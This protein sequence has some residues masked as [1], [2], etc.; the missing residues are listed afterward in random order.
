MRLHARQAIISSFFIFSSSFVLSADWPQWRGPAQT[1]HV[2]AGVAVPAALP[3]EAKVLWRVKIGDGYASPV[4]CGGKV[5]YLDNQQGDETVHA[6]EAATGKELWHARL[7]ACFKDN[8]VSG[9]RCT[10]TADGNRVYAQSCRG[11]FQCLN[12]DDGKVVWRKNFCTDFGSIFIGEKGAATG[13]SRHGYAGAPVVDGENIIV[14]VG[15]TKGACLVCMK[16]ATGDV[17]WQSQND[18]TAYGPPVLATLCGTKQAVAFTVEGVIGVDTTDGKLLWRSAPMKTAFGRHIATAVIV[19]DLVLVASHQIGLIA[20]R[21]VKDGGGLKAETAWTE[22][23]LAINFSSPVAVGKYLYGLGPAKNIICV[24][25][26]TGS[27][28][29]EKTGCIVSPPD[30]A[31][32]AFL[33][34]GQNILL[35]TD[36]GLLI[37]FAADPQEYKEL[38][39]VQVCGQAWCN[40]AYVDGKLFLRDARELLCVE[41]LK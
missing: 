6:A 23:P 12:A 24:D 17:L 27:R 36:S 39:R 14:G 4:V 25:V 1:G 20:T 34:L 13:A 11:E 28:A 37:L 35:L 22:K 8:F 19:D 10:P 5:F 41:L 15:S 18:Q 21:I 26:Q 7:D 3:A 29:W 40:P 33:V 9:P 38:S 30:K 32:A 31:H 16:K 2:P